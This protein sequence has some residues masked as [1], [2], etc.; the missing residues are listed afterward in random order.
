MLT[1][2]GNGMGAY[3]FENLTLS[4]EAYDTIV[5]DKN[6]T[7]DAPNLLKLSYKEAKACTFYLTTKQRTSCMW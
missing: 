5:C 2:A 1:I 4:L 6:F 7:E 3:T